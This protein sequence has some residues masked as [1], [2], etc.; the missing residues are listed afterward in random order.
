MKR[1]SWLVSGVL[2]V[3][4]AVVVYSTFQIGGV[5]C[6]VCIQFHGREV[7]RSVD[8]TTEAEALSAATTNACALLTSGVTNVLA[9]ERTPPRVSECRAF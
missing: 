8:G 5:R 6:E 1:T 2:V 7:C 3:L 9:C 4:I